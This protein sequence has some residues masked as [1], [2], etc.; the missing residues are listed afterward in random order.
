MELPIKEVTGATLED[1]L[2]TNA[3]QQI[4]PARYLNK[5]GDGNVVETPEELFERV[6]KNVAV[7]EAVHTDEPVTITP[8]EIKPDHPRR[9]ELIEDIWFNLAFTEE[10]GE[11]KLI[12]PN[13][14]EYVST[15]KVSPKTLTD[16]NAKWVSF[17]E[18]HSRCYD[19]SWNETLDHIEDVRDEFKERMTHLDFMPNSPTLMNAGSELQQLSACFVDSPKDDMEDIHETEKEAAQVFQSGGGMGYSFSRLRPYGDQVGST[20]GI[21]SGPVTFMRT[22]DQMC[23]TIAQ[24]GTRR[25]AQM[26]IMRVTHP[27]VIQ[28]IHAKNKD[29]SL[30]QAL[31]LNDPK[32]FT[33]TSFSGA[34][35]EA[36]E[37]L[38]DFGGVPHFLRNAVEAHLANFNI[39]VAVTDEFMDAVKNDD[40]FTFK[41]PRTGEAH[42]ASQQTKEMYSWFGLGEYVEPGEPL[43]LP[44]NE[45]WSRIID[46]AHENGEPGVVYIDRINEQHSFPAEST[47]GN[48]TDG[49]YEVLATNPCGEQPLM[50]YE[51]CNLG[52]INLSTLV[53]GDRTLWTEWFDDEYPDFEPEDLD[54]ME[55]R[56]AVQDFLRE[57]VD[58]DDLH[59]RVETGTRFL[60]NV[61]T[62]SAFPIEKIEETVRNNR[63]VGL[64]IMGMAQMFIQMGVEYGTTEGNEVA[65]QLMR[66]INQKSKA[67]SHNL[68][69]E[70]GTFGNWNDSKWAD[71][72][73]Y[74]DFFER[75]TGLDPSDW[76]DGY[77]IRNH[78]TTTI[79]PTGTT[80]MI[81]NTSGGCEPIPNVAYLKNVG[82]DV[83]GEEQLVEFDDYFLRV[84][85]ANNIDVDAVKAEA[86]R[87]MEENEHEDYS[88]IEGLSTVPD[89][90]GELFVVTG[91]LS[92]KQHAA[93][94]TACQFGVDSAISKTV[95]APHEATK[96]DTAE[97]FEFVYDHG[98]KGVTYYRDGT[99]SKQVISTREKN[100]EFADEEDLLE[101]V[102]A[103]VEEDEEFAE[104]LAD[105]VPAL[106]SS[107]ARTSAQADGKPKA[108]PKVTR[109]ETH[110]VSTGYGTM[111]VT[112]NED[113]DGLH[114]VFGTIGKSGGF[115]ES[116]VEG[117]CRQISLSL[118]VGA[119]VDE[120]IHQLE[121]ISSPQPGWDE[122][123]QISSIPDGIATALKRY[124]EARGEPEIA[125]EPELLA[126]KEPEAE[127]VRDGS[128]GG[129]AEVVKTG[130]NPECP[131]C[132]TMKVM[133][134]GCESCPS[135]DCDWSKC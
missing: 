63:K 62:M 125:D 70:R 128:G 12:S 78:N 60:D 44:A 42:I 97:A 54:E 33:H 65:R 80:S 103:K 117:L 61:V 105:T 5:D 129:T 89:E 26:G 92:G 1:R 82:Q 91:D 112:I 123:E 3:Y 113:A 74:P 4:L 35:E 75:H 38:D 93:V 9:K 16:K 102:E 109:G 40:T 39:S 43:E 2:T 134:E 114:E 111:Y 41:N 24:G 37:I 58:W 133:S 108:R 116:M 46:G 32:D 126:K 31:R 6:A 67:V 20:G 59:E 94:Q 17:D 69:E 10:D 18:L 96:D 13:D 11:V 19:E 66:A 49:K 85:E 81:G 98:G 56:F 68:A 132:G 55:L 131:K 53:D 52:H 106:Q 21:A 79:A 130:S 110:R 107:D 95:N 84:L 120:V 119:D 83:Q 64:G 72:T 121:D 90:I 57:A 28:F 127:A 51:A 118:R 22:F 23:R 27:D 99:R 101:T 122:G 36:R 71:P 25:G 76:E 45:L 124:Q 104:E 7:A 14:G 8:Q 87:Q 50:E 48:E 73:S 86:K 115:T 100:K 88:G 77:P 29:V 15:E 47:P 30:A 34:L 135:D